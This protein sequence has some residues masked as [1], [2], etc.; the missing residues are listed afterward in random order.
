MILNMENGIKYYQFKLAFLTDSADV[1]SSLERKEDIVIVDV[2]AEEAY[3]AEHIPGAINLHYKNMNSE[4][5]GILD[6]QTLYV[7]YCH[8]IGC[9]ASTKGALNMARLGFR[10]KELIGGIEWW[11]KD[12]YPVVTVKEQKEDK[13]YNVGCDCD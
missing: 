7:T 13:E 12:G 6:K 8:G 10:V 5:T 3:D 9:N 11:K 1:M 2:R 4:T